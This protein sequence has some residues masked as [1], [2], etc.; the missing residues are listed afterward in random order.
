M[1]TNGCSFY[2]IARSGR[3]VAEAVGV[4]YDRS[5]CHY[6]E[7]ATPAGQHFSASKL[8]D[9]LVGAQVAAGC[10]RVLKRIRDFGVSQN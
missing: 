2:G 4:G 8:A 6:N 5:H 9:D 3:T 1:A 10:F 7:S